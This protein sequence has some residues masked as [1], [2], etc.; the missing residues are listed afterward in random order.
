MTSP[1]PDEILES[2]Y[3]R[4]RPG[5]RGWR[6]IAVKAGFGEEGIEGGALPWTN[7]IAGI[8]A[9]YSTLFG[10]GKLV[11]GE[12]MVGLALLVI[13]LAAFAWI[14]RSFRGAG[15]SGAGAETDRSVASRA[16]AAETA[17]AAALP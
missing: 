12:T 3:R 4:V 17:A 9:V 2:F 15:S 14:S 1:E 7:W 11:F 13:A 5:G 6:R 16:Q 8:V 10:I